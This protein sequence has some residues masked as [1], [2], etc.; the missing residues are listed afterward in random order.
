MIVRILLEP[1]SLHS[2]SYHRDLRDRSVTETV[3]PEG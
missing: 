2:V 3:T 1:T